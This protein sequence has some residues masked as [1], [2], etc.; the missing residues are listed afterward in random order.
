MQQQYH[1]LSLLV[2]VPGDLVGIQQ[3]VVVGEPAVSS[4]TQQAI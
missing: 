1:I 4:K 2:V 3:G